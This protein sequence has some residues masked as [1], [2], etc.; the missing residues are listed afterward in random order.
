MGISHFLQYRGTA[1]DSH[2]YELNYFEFTRILNL[3][4]NLVGICGSD[5]HILVHGKCSGTVEFKTP[6]IC[7]HESSAIVVEIGSNVKHLKVGD[8]VAIEPAVPCQTCFT[9]KQGSYNLCPDMVC[10]ADPPNDGCLRR[11]YN[12]NSNFCHK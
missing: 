1:D 4:L 8:K 9:C 2:G 11:F 10:Q 3:F 12:H 7:G 5:V 6:M